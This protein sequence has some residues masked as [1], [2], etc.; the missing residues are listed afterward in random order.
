MMDVL[1]RLRALNCDRSDIDELVALQSFAEVL[2]ATYAGSGLV[3]PEWLSDSLVTLKREIADRRRDELLREAKLLDAQE[4]R[5]LSREEQRD[6]V[7]RRRDEINKLL[8]V[9]A[10]S[11]AEVAAGK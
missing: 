8:G 6:K 4:N 7:R 3:V 5:L 1:N 9:S 10:G 11:A 2:Q